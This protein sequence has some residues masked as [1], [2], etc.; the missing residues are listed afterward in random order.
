VHTPAYDLYAD[1]CINIISDVM[2][3]SSAR[4]YI[5]VSEPEVLNDMTNSSAGT[6][7]IDVIPPPDTSYWSPVKVTGVTLRHSLSTVMT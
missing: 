2:I 6:G 5:N 4:R 7:T 3:S 1:N